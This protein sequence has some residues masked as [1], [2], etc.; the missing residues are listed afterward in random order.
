[1]EIYN[2]D[3]IF[4]RWKCPNESWIKLNCDGAHYKFVDLARCGGL[5]RDSNDQW[6]QGRTQK[7]GTCDSLHA[8][9]W[10]MYVGL[11]LARRKGVTHLIV[12]SDSK[13][14]IDMVTGRCKLN[15]ATPILLRR[16][17]ELISMDWQTQFSHTWR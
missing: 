13:I 2:R 16:I 9:M 14:L 10:G 1:M 15:G 5:L 12:E 7:I 4:I 3:T 8:E 17:Q 11:E 6:I